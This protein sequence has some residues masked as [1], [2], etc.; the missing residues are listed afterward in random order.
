M[1][2]EAYEQLRNEL[3][4]IVKAK[5]DALSDVAALRI[6]VQQQRQIIDSLEEARNF[7]TFQEKRG[8]SR[9]QQPMPAGGRPEDDVH[10]VREWLSGMLK[11]RYVPHAPLRHSLDAVGEQM[12]SLKLELR[13]CLHSL[14]LALQAPEKDTPIKSGQRK[15]E[16]PSPPAQQAGLHSELQRSQELTQLLREQLRQRDEEAERMQEQLRQMQHNINQQ[17]QHTSSEHAVQI[18]F[19]RENLSRVQQL[20]RASDDAVAKLQRS[21]SS[22]RLQKRYLSKALAYSS[23]FV[24]AVSLHCAARDLHTP[25]ASNCLPPTSRLRACAYVIIAAHRLHRASSS[26]STPLSRSCFPVAGDADFSSP[27]AST[28]AAAASDGARHARSALQVPPRV[29]L[30]M[31]C[32]QATACDFAFTFT[33]VSCVSTQALQ[34]SGVIE[35]EHLRGVVAHLQVG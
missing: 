30:L 9:Q 26:I 7:D 34:D 28:C 2:L 14:R 13:Q 33:S 21:N 20:Q 15:G 32:V 16:G 6:I 10:C 27:I 3:K 1:Q 35:L 29:F 23:S 8:A 18:R 4:A 12:R 31:R 5:C 11:R 19:L 24:S 22:L 17:Q 25:A